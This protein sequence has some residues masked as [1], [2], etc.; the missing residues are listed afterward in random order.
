MVWWGSFRAGKR[1]TVRLMGIHQPPST[2]FSEARNRMAVPVLRRR[3]SASG[4]AAQAE[5]AEQWEGGESV[6]DI[7]G[8]G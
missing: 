5:G 4:T 1:G 7:G 2:C 6:W 8:R 3:L